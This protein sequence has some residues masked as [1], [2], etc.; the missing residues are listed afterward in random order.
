MGD[1]T[2][3]SPA[4]LEPAFRVASSHA[5]RVDD[6]GAAQSK[7][8]RKGTLQ[9]ASSPIATGGSSRAVRGRETR[10][11]ERSGAFDLAATLTVLDS[12]SAPP[13][14]SSGEGATFGACCSL[15]IR[16]VV[17]GANATS[18]QIYGRDSH[19]PRPLWLWRVEAGEAS[20]LARGESLADGSLAFASV[21][22]PRAGL[23]LIATPAGARP[24]RED[25]SAPLH[26]AGPPLLPPRA[27][28]VVTDSGEWRLRLVPREP[29]A[30]IVLADASGREL[31]R[32]PARG[33]PD[34]ARRSF[35][36]ELSEFSGAEGA[37]VAHV[38]PDGRRSEWRRVEPRTV[39]AIW[40]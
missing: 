8:E 23:E 14:S 20:L 39:T 32:I 27:A 22:L 26:I 17:D 18:V 16:A 33:R 11:R 24:G 25:A 29:S 10:A 30:E 38:L 7:S 37:K 31:A 28:V 34:T 35:E 1:A 5:S 36:I 2:G 40:E 15:E 19:A 3:R 13:E 12:T 6:R 9:T 4:R 21:I